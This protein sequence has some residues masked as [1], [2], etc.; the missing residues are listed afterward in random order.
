MSFSWVTSARRA[1]LLENREKYLAATDGPD[2]KT[3]LK[4]IKEGIRTDTGRKTPKKLNQVGGYFNPHACD[5]LQVFFQAIDQWYTAYE[6][7]ATEVVGH[8]EARWTKRWTLRKV[9]IELERQA[10]DA[11]I[12]HQPGSLEY[13]AAHPQ[14]VSQIVDELSEEKVMEYQLLAKQWNSQGPPRDVQLKYITFSLACSSYLNM[15]PK[16]SR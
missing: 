11:R 1:I 6:S 4:T 15:L 9:V 10:I 3:I 7:N 16:A 13:L 12:S 8:G 14:V 2:R 5:Q